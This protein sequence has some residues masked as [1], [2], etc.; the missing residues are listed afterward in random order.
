MQQTLG[1]RFKEDLLAQ[2][3]PK[4]VFYVNGETPEKGQA[5]GKVRAALTAEVRD[6]A[7]LAKTLDKVMAVVTQVLQGQAAQNPRARLPEVR[8][9][10]GPTPGYRLILPPGS[11]P[12]NMEGIID[13]TL[14]VGKSQLVLGLNGD[15]ARAVA[16]GTTTWTP[17]PDYAVPFAKLPKD[18]IALSIDDPRGGPAARRG[19]AGPGRDGEHD[20][21]QPAAADGAPAIQFHL[22]P[23]NVPTAE[24]VSRRLFPNT[25]AISIDSDGLTVTGR[26]SVPG[27]SGAG[28]G[29]RRHRAAPARRP[30]RAARPRG[31]RSAS[32]TSSRLVLRCSITRRP[33]AASPRRRSPARTASRS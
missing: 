22:D 17:G 1:L 15:E 11:M 16:T 27:L 13:P 25:V 23:A 9:A 32:T 7:A 30:G 6:G 28:G 19:R 3:G 33:T 4:W 21:R 5:M 31:G 20:D 8:K 29:R 14:L 12:P 2:L 24:E 26:E 18:L 10:E